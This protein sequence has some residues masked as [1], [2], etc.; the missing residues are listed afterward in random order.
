MRQICLPLPGYEDDEPV[1]IRIQTGFKGK[2]VVFRLEPVKWLQD[3]DLIDSGDSLDSLDI[4]LSRI[5]ELKKSI[6]SYD[7]SWELIQIFAPLKNS[8]FL[9]I[10]YR[11]RITTK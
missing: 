1:E 10:L 4:S 5:N 7:K 6:E 8:N 9:R 11:K 3:K 2:T